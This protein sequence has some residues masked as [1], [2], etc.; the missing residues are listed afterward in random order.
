MRSLD[1]FKYGDKDA[2]LG[3]VDDFTVKFTFGVA[4][5]LGVYYDLS[6][7]GFIIS[8]KHIL[9]IFTRP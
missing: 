3:E 6:E 7:A 8:P 9:K 2:K 4:K 1:A 5:P